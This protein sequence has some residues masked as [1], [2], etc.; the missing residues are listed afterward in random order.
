[1]ASHDPW[2]TGQYNTVQSSCTVHMYS[3]KLYFVYS[4][5][6]YSFTVLICTVYS[7]YLYIEVGASILKSSST[8]LKSCF[9]KKYLV[10]QEQCPEQL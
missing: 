4:F 9:L 3:E 6:V 1:M 8:Y 10:L 7:A 2:V 5:T